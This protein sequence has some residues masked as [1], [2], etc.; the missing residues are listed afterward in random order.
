MFSTASCGLTHA[1][2]SSLP[3]VSVPALTETYEGFAHD[4]VREGFGVYKYH[5]LSV[6]E[7]GWQDGLRHG[8]GR[9]VNGK[10]S[11]YEGRFHADQMH[12]P[13]VYITEDVSAH[14]A[15][16]VALICRRRQSVV[17]SDRGPRP[18]PPARAD[19]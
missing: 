2:P 8:W 5:D 7:G 18:P 14:Q 1:G 4:G 3:L 15:V 16:D 10:R 17:F 12:G 6:Y 13:G 11:M 9:H 19:R